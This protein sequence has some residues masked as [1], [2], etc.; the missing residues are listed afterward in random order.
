MLKITSERE[1]IFE[2]YTIIA[3]SGMLAI[4]TCI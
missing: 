2:K 1:I 4:G 3:G